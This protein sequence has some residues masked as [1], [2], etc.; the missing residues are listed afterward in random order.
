VEQANG[1][2]IYRMVDCTLEVRV[3]SRT[4]IG[5]IVPTIEDVDQFQDFI[6]LGIE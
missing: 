1:I 3:F 2:D 6:V 5:T 4:P